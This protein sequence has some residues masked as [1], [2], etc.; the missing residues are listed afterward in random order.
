MK[1][2][3][4]LEDSLTFNAVLPWSHFS[5]AGGKGNRDAASSKL[6]QEKVQLRYKISL[7]ITAVTYYKETQ[8]LLFC[9]VC[10]DITVVGFVISHFTSS[11][12]LLINNTGSILLKENFFPLLNKSVY[13][14]WKKESVYGIITG[15]SW[16][17]KLSE[18]RI[19]WELQICGAVCWEGRA[20]PWEGKTRGYTL[21]KTSAFSHLR[22]TPDSRHCGFC[23]K[24]NTKF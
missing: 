17:L 11:C 3:F 15:S 6:L 23:A 12:R 24:I 10:W 16:L 8:L 4:A 13:Q 5:T 21:F 20:I 22:K 2:D 1:P 14:I 18:A 7:S 19:Y 9:T